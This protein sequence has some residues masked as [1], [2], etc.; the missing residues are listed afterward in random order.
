M[1]ERIELGGVLTCVNSE[2]KERTKDP[3]NTWGLSCLSREGH[4]GH[5]GCW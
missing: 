5:I 4:M 1:V 2:Q 3:M